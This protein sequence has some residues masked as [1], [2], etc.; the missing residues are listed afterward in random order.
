[1]VPQL[2][3]QEVRVVSKEASKVATAEE[4]V[5]KLVSLILFSLVISVSG[6]K[7]ILS[8]NSLLPVVPFHKLELL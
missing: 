2:E 3:E 8:D 6:P 5:V 1:M 4:M 7:K